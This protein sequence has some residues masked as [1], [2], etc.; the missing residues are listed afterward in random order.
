MLVQV[1]VTFIKVPLLSCETSLLDSL[2]LMALL[3]LVESRLSSQPAGCRTVAPATCFP[4]RLYSTRIPRCRFATRSQLLRATL[5]PPF[6]AR[7][8]TFR[9]TYLP[10]ISRLVGVEFSARWLAGKRR[11]WRSNRANGSISR[12]R[13]LRL[14]L[15]FPS[16]SSCSA[17]YTCKSTIQHRHK[18]SCVY[19]TVHD[20][21]LLN[22]RNHINS[23]TKVSVA[24]RIP[25]CIHLNSANFKL[26]NSCKLAFQHIPHTMF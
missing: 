23:S 4:S 16:L 12:C 5:L 20:L 22:I 6:T 18:Q 9:G 8:A 1:T 13:R 21:W 17:A 24:S 15:L 11:W 19:H 2:L 14:T 10:R 7:I 3:G 26:F 25:L